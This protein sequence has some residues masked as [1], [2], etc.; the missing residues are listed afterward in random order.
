MPE[1]T[2]N[3]IDDLSMMIH[4]SVMDARELL[5]LESIL[6]KCGD[7]LA[8]SYLYG[9][10]AWGRNTIRSANYVI[11]FKRREDLR[12]L[13]IQLTTNFSDSNKLLINF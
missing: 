8:K 6:K 5:R 7:F 3:N 2:K 4:V 10:D 9:R 13:K 12:R 1:R 11:K